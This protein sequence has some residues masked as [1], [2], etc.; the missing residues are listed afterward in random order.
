MKCP[1]P[2]TAAQ[3]AREAKYQDAAAAFWSRMRL[4]SARFEAID[5]TRQALGQPPLARIGGDTGMSADT[6][7]APL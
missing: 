1:K 2:A 3:R 7:P 5:E 6:M 4:G